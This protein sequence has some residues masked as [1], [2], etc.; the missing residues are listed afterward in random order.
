MPAKEEIKASVRARDGFKCAK[1]G[2]TNEENIAKS[3][4]CLDVHRRVPASKYTVD[5]CITLCKPCHR[6]AH[7]SGEFID[8]PKGS[9][10]GYGSEP[11]TFRLHDC[12]RAQLEKL[13]TRNATRLSTEIIAAMREHLERNGMW[14]PPEDDD[15]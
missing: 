7:T 9:V 10:E 13:A 15:E 8:G 12:L 1:C 6:K 2:L 3:G 11:F 5:G 14:P 4:V